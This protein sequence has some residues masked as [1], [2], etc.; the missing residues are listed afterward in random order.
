[1]I[2]LLLLVVT[3]QGAHAGS[4]DFV[5]RPKGWMILLPPLSRPDH[6]TG[7]RTI[8]TSAPDKQWTAIVVRGYDG[9]AYDFSDEHGCE[10]TKTAWWMKL[11]K[12]SYSSD[13]AVGSR[14]MLAKAKCLPD[15]GRRHVLAR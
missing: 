8:L 5:S 6:I 10:A 4:S 13:A 1:L 7:E 14:N 12:E 3:E 9:G 15:D 11:Y 2:C